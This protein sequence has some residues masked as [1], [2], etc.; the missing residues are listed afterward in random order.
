MKYQ[1]KIQYTNPSH[2]HVS[3]RRRVE[4]VTR[5]VEAANEQEAIN[6]AANQQRALGFIIKEA[7]VYAPVTGLHSLALNNNEPQKGKEKKK[8]LV[9]KDG[10]K[11]DI[12]ASGGVKKEEKG[13]TES[14]PL[15]KK[16][17]KLKPMK[18][19]EGFDTDPKDIA[20]YLVDRHGKGKVTMDH[21]E[22]YERRRD[23]HR[24][25]EKH[26]VMKHVKKMSEEVEQV[27][28]AKQVDHAKT[29]AKSLAATH[30]NF[31]VSSYDGDYGRAHVVHHKSD[32]RNFK[33][34]E[35]LMGPNIQL[36]HNH[37]TNKV[38]ME[39]QGDF[40]NVP[41]RDEETHHPDKA[42]AAAHKMFKPA[43]DLI[44]KT[45]KT[46]TNE[47]VEQVDEAQK[48]LKPSYWRAEWRM[49]TKSEVDKNN[50][51]IYDRLVKTDPEKAAKFHDNLMKIRKEEVEAVEEGAKDWKRAFGKV[52]QKNLT[53]DLSSIRSKVHRMDHIGL[54][55][56]VS[57]RP[58]TARDKNRKELGEANDVTKDLRTSMKAMDL[59]HGVDADKRVAGY[60]M[61]DAVRKAQK[62][63]DELSKVEKKPQAGTLVAQKSRKAAEKMVNRAKGN[64]N[65]IDVAPTIEPGKPNLQR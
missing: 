26:E 63:S 37:E 3:L 27:E 23:S 50:K 35:E 7:E 48:K 5:L 8:E 16:G 19:G 54:Q 56:K 12:A 38:H 61:S 58:V 64:A 39:M 46:T 22:A 43:I 62:K 6:R 53:K 21:I 33:N 10:E 20:A 51:K 41:D 32:T 29:I 42:H 11:T 2:E 9:G 34:G 31:R 28:E 1:V 13:G 44:H 49:G 4:S 25:I 30:P 15:L 17:E 40:D 36:Q 45:D 24:P 52:A 14:Y 65:K 47:E 60:K 57:E 55:P 18:I 59:R